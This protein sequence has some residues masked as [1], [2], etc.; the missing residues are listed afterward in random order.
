MRSWIHQR[1]SR[2]RLPES[3][4]LGAVAGGEGGGGERVEWPVTFANGHPD[5]LFHHKGRLSLLLER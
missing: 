5:V 1:L 4:T 3:R 2:G